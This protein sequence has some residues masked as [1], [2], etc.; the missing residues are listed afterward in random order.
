MSAALFEPDEALALSLVGGPSVPRLAA[1]VERYGS[2]HAFMSQ[3]DRVLL[4]EKGIG[5][6]TLHKL[7]RSQSVDLAK[8]NARMNRAGIVPLIYG[9][10]GYPPALSEGMFDP[11]L[12]LYVKGDA[13]ACQEA[14]VAVVGTRRPS[15]CG[16]RMARLLGRDLG[17]FPFIVVSG[18]ATGI[19]GLAHASCLKA[20]GRTMA[21]LA[22]GHHTIEPSAHRG[23]ARSI[24]E[25]GGA[26][27][28]EYPWGVEARKHTFVPRN[29]IIAGL[30]A[31]TVVVE[32]GLKSGA[33]HTAE[34][35]L[36]YGRV[37]LAVPGRP[38]D[39]QA[40]LPNELIREKK[41]ELCRGL[42]DVLVSLPLHQVDGVREAIDARA[43]I[44]ARKAEKAL[45]ALGSEAETL[46]RQLGSDPLHVD[47]LCNR[48]GM[49]PAAVLAA[50]LQMEIEGLVEQLP[51]MRYVANCRL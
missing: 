29:R 42:E 9:H 23:L 8:A 39:P 43:H 37:L 7:R 35:A 46:F 34:F 41:A 24:L 32:G 31:A 40:A 33:R 6:E 20:K 18:L 16:E 27:V 22:H 11:P 47:D 49:S 36:E 4:A 1:I 50:L 10:P 19:D 14:A 13:G 30:A 17:S 48:T 44:L 25:T 38:S 28:S 3:P 26:L 21:V 5:P 45:R 51:G 15:P 2:L 12:V